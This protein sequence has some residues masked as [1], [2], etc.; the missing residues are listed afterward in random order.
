[1]DL[2]KVL[3]G[4]LLAF[5]ILAIVYWAMGWGDDDEKDKDDQT[6]RPPGAPGVDLATG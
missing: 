5:A 3:L 2:K 1:M 4:L 6:P